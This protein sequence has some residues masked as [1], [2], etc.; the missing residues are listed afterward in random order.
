MVTGIK[1]QNL[2][3]NFLYISR[4]APELQLTMLDPPSPRAT[5]K[6]FSFSEWSEQGWKDERTNGNS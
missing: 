5:S 3:E 1:S 2:R 6:N 4:Q